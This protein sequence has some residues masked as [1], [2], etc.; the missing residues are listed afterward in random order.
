MARISKASDRRL[1]VGS[2]LR[3]SGLH[4]L[5]RSTEPA[6]HD[7]RASDRRSQNLI[8]C[9]IPLARKIVIEER[10]DTHEHVRCGM[11]KQRREQVYPKPMLVGMRRR[12]GAAPHRE[13]TPTDQ[14][15]VL[16]RLVVT[17]R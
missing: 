15:H 17:E 10:T 1:C 14:V 3:R 6:A 4:V 5:S 13:R 12:R 7:K 16:D 9:T 8:G 11:N 2:G